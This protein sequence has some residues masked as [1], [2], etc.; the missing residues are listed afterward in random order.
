MV[1]NTIDKGLLKEIEDEKECRQTG[2]RKEV[3]PTFAHDSL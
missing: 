2:R 1:G 3:D